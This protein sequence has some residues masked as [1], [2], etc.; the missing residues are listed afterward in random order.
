MK[1]F[2]T[3]TKV[4]LVALFILSAVEISAQID[5]LDP[6]YY[7]MI[8]SSRNNG[9]AYV[10]LGVNLVDQATDQA[11][12]EKETADGFSEGQLWQII[13][14]NDSS[15]R[16]K[17]KGTGMAI[18]ITTWRGLNPS[19]TDPADV[20][21]F[22]WNGWWH[23]VCQRTWDNEDASQVW[24]PKKYVDLVND[25]SRYRL[26][27]MSGYPDSLF[28]WNLWRNT[29]VIETDPA[30]TYQNKNVALINHTF[31]QEASY[32]DYTRGYSYFFTQSILEVPPSALDVNY[33][34]EIAVFASE[35]TI[36]IRGEL[37]NKNIEVYTILGTKVYSDIGKSTDLYIPVKKGVYIVRTGKMITKLVVH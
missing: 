36:N 37:L 19:I 15:Y 20:W 32:T 25:T 6:T 31:V 27:N 18:G 7:Y 12:L 8:Q 14:V 29:G 3:I 17:N 10:A 35:N 26:A 11:L 13:A 4:V 2:F 24:V 9:G 5:D 22:I 34:E 28:V 1:K 16:F 21:N 33:Q 30:L 23:G